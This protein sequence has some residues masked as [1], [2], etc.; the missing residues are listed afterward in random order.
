M[1]IHID[2][3]LAGI[4]IVSLLIGSLAG[5]VVGFVAGAEEGHGL[6]ER[7]SRFNYK[8]ID[9]HAD[10]ETNDDKGGVPNQDEQTVTPTD[11]PSSSPVIPSARPTTSPKTH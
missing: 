10:G 1:D 5:G 7:G 9:D 2:R 6:H 3:K 4:V 8:G 11:Q